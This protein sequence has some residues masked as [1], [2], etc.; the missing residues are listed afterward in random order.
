MALAYLS[1]WS[2]PVSESSDPYGSSKKTGLSPIYHIQSA[3]YLPKSENAI[4]EAIMNGGALGTSIHADAINYST[5]YNETNSALYYYGSGKVDHD[6]AIVGWDDNYSRNNFNTVPPNN[7]AWIIR[8]SWGSG[9]GDN[10]YF[11]LSYYD[12]YAAMRLSPFI[13]PNRLI[14]ISASI[15]MTLLVTRLP[16]L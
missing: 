11:Y 4:K 9:W 6:V 16:W 1:R 7:G 2:S 15:T 10:D 5:Y 3:Q 14:I 12:T 8:N 13:T